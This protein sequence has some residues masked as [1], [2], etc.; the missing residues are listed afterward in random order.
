MFFFFP[1]TTDG[2]SKA[3]E[4]YS[5]SPSVLE[6][7]CVSVQTSGQLPV[8]FLGL[9]FH[10]NLHRRTEN[11]G[12]GVLLTGVLVSVAELSCSQPLILVS[13]ETRFMHMLKGCC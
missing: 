4:H 1:R 6:G 10:S 5:V 3:P 11:S 2:L 7:S 13:L 8:V 9:L 12:A